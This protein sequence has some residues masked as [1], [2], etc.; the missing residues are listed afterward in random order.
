MEPESALRTDGSGGYYPTEDT[1]IDSPKAL[2]AHDSPF[3]GLFTP[4][5]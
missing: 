4:R 1:V 5:A 3:L 2:Q